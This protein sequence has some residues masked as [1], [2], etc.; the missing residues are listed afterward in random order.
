V[1]SRAPRSIAPEGLSPGEALSGAGFAELTLPFGSSAMR[2]SN[3]P[4][5]PL[6]RP[7]PLSR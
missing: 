7:K 5:R 1:R 6:S 4:S 3:K 2:Y